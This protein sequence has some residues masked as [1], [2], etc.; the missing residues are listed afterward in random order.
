MKIH[1]Q[2]N[3]VGIKKFTARKTKGEKNRKKGEK[4]RKRNRHNSDFTILN[5]VFVSLDLFE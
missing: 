3:S 4:Q 5:Y 2:A 1:F